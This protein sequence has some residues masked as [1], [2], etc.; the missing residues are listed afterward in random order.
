MGTYNPN[1]KSS[2]SLL[3]G[4]RGL[5]GL[6][7]TVIVGVTRFPSAGPGSFLRSRFASSSTRALQ[8]PLSAPYEIRQLLP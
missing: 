7:C 2:Y 4:L 3:R 6:I 5:R 1:H 8:P